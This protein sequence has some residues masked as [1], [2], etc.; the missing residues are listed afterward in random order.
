MAHSKPCE[1]WSIEGPW[2]QAAGP[3]MAE[4]KLEF[5]SSQA[6]ADPGEIDALRVDLDAHVGATSFAAGPP[7]EGEKSGLSVDIATLVITLLGTP[8]AVALVG[9]LKSYFDRDRV[10]EVKLSGPGG[11]VELKLPAGSKLSTEQIQRAIDGVLGPA[12]S[13]P[14]A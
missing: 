13:A 11:S 9:V 14:G 7:R 3:I 4:L 5:P 2:I 8:A 12:P 6:Q 10:T 1:K